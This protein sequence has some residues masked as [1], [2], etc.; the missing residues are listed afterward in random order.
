MAKVLITGGCGFIGS[1]LTAKFLADGDEVTVF[2]NLSRRGT[3]RNLEWLRGQNN[4]KFHF[5]QGDIRDSAA[6]RD[7]VAATD[8]DLVFHTAAQVAV[9]TSVTDPRTDFEVNALGTF[10]VLEAVRASGR[11]PIV[12]FT[13]TNKVYGGMEDV[14]IVERDGRYDYEDL[15]HGVPESR[16][17][18]FHSPYGCSKGAADQYVRDYARIYGIPT[19]VFRMSCQ[20]G[21]RQFGNEDQGWVAHFVIAAHRGQSINIYGDGK[22]VRDIL[23]IDDLVRAFQMAA[24]SISRT[25]GKIYNIGGGRPN[26]ISLLELVADLEQIVGHD[27]PLN[28]GP[29]RPGDQPVYISDIRQAQEDFGWA[30]TISKAEGVRRLLEW[31]RANPALFE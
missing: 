9:T 18:D 13:S 27:I 4:P 28:F 23:Y 29:W 16:G 30:P 25:A 31:V 22:Q 5:V 11:K 24:Q 6:I 3:E 21:P 20:Y 19:V 15:P 8:Y 1:N 12:F 26:T 17:L 7:V 2:D 10:N 14:K